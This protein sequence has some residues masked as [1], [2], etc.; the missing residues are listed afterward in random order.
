M[1]GHSTFSLISV[2]IPA[3]SISE[4]LTR[5]VL[6]ALA[7]TLRRIEIL[8]VAKDPDGLSKQLLSPIKDARLKIK[9]LPSNAAFGDLVNEGVRQ[10]KSS[11]IAFLHEYDEWLPRKL[12]LQFQ[13]GQSLDTLY[14]VISCRLSAK[15]KGKEMI[16]PRRFPSRHEDL[17]EYLFC[18]KTPFYGEGL[19]KFSTILTKKEL[20]TKVPFDASLTRHEDYDWL[21]RI[22]SFQGASI[23][24]ADTTD[25]LVIWS[26]EGE[27][28][29]PK[30]GF[31]LETTLSWQQRR[32]Q[33]FT[34]RAYACFLLTGVSR[35]VNVD[36][37]LK[38]FFRL[39]QEAF[40]NG[41]P[42][43]PDF[44][45]SIL[46]WLSPRTLQHKVALF[47]ARARGFSGQGPRHH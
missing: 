9:T 8:V 42:L 1:E 11:W 32:K 12:E 23:V 34:P 20:L 2:V 3:Y 46:I 19:I 36:R 7:Q 10:A 40:R 43:I 37:N 4:S 41:R 35:E 39:F 27:A 21:L 38:T 5:S 13:K 44:L 25:P 17:S 6:S 28:K 26:M 29:R 18:Q 30:D 15:S 47:F 14:P 45:W 31:D 22:K 16:W 24:F 33:F